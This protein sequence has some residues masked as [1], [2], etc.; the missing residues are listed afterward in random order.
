MGSLIDSLNKIRKLAIISLFHDDDL[1][2]L[3]VLKGGNAL[4]IIYGINNRA[5][6]DID[7]SM[8]NDL[9]KEELKE[10]ESKL[11]LAFDQ[12]F[13]VNGFHVFD[14]KIN[15]TPKTIPL[16]YAHF[17]GGY[18][19][20]L[21]IIE[22]DQ[23][24]Q[25]SDSIDQLRRR[26]VVVGAGQEKILKIDISKYEFITPKTLKYLDGYGIY[27]YTPVMVVYEKLRAICQQMEEYVQY[28][29]TNRKPRA[30]DFFD[31]Y[32]IVEKWSSPVDVYNLH[33]IKLLPQIFDIKRVPTN[34]LCLMENYRE[35]HRDNFNSVQDTVIVDRLES[36]DFYFD[37]VLEMTRKLWNILDSGLM[38]ET[39]AGFETN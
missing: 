4:N 21:K 28:V 7:I 33:N 34:F 39:A 6:M 17:W 25:F 36:Y 18:T 8:E 35:Y 5:S 23:Y 11:K 10:F 14:F 9:T 2:S 31:I 32:T 12:V 27:V 24:K 13:N 15:P 3:F 20:E 38:D 22:E 37:Y 30:R 19:V 1:L 16:E 26:A 29:S